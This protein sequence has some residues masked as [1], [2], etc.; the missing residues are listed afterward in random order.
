[1]R[2]A[3]RPRPTRA[4]LDCDA[5]R[6]SVLPASWPDRM[7]VAMLAGRVFILILAAGAASCGPSASKAGLDSPVSSVRIDAIA[8]AADTNDRTAI[9]KLVELLNSDDIVVRFTAIGALTRLT[10]RTY[11]FAADA[12]A[13]Q[14]REAI[15]RW[16]A[17][18][19]SGEFN[20]SSTTHD[21][22]AIDV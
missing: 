6:L 16:V 2:Q 5:A 13:P 21:S 8:R 18:V 7:L 19:K 12:P 4:T 17:A 11:D 14:R 9:P 1:M 15:D 22:G 20:R 3:A 10:G